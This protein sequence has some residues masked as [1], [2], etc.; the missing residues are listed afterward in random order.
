MKRTE[1]IS[2]PDVLSIPTGVSSN[3]RLLYRRI[4]QSGGVVVT[5]DQLQ[6]G[7]GPKGRNISTI[8]NYLHMIKKIPSSTWRIVNVFGT[9]YRAV[10]A[11]SKLPEV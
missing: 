1:S 9:G 3:A 4:I 7:L 6:E 2:S 8:R 11:D 10:R 5:Y